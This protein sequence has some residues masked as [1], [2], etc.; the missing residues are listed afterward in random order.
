MAEITI[1]SLVF[2]IVGGIIPALFWLWF[3]LREDKTRPEPAG[4][5]ILTF[6]G[7]AM[8]VFIAL[9]FQ[10]IT[11]DFFT[12]EFHLIISWAV[13]EETVK[14]VIIG[15]LV[16]QSRYLD[17]PIDYIVYLVTGALGFAAMEN[18]LYLLNSYLIDGAAVSLATGNLRF[19]GA[20]LLHAVATSTVGVGLGLAF[21]KPKIYRKI[22]LV[23]G[24]LFAIVLHGAFNFFIMKGGAVEIIFA[25]IAL[26]IVVII[27]MFIFERIRYVGERVH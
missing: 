26:W 3:W 12:Q 16:F 18:I 10:A 21:Y 1:K 20:T 11:K 6:L 13:I 22:A 2:A 15:I 25:L 27:R 23:V 19:I 4:F 9:F 8:A 14:L 7:G 24:L 17:E 5:L